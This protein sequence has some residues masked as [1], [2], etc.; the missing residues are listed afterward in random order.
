[1]QI[2]LFSSSHVVSLMAVEN[3]L[4]SVVSEEVNVRG[5]E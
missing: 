2:A 3:D 4:F 1:M 5:S